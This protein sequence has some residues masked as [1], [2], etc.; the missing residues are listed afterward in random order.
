MPSFTLFILISRLVPE[1]SP[2]EVKK[3]GGEDLK[4]IRTEI[5][6]ITMIK[7]PGKQRG[8]TMLLFV[9]FLAGMIGMIGLATDTGDILVNK[10]RLQ[11]AMDATALSAATILS[12][13]PNRD[14][15][16]ATNNAINTFNLFINTAGN[17]ALSSGVSANNLTF[18]FSTTLNPFTAQNFAPGANPPPN[19]VRVSTNALAVSPILRQVVATV[20]AAPVNVPAVATAGVAGQNCNLTP[21]VICPRP[22]PGGNP[23]VGCG[24]NSGFNGSGPGCN[25]ISFNELVCLKGGTQAARTGTCQSTNVP[26]GNFGMLNFPNLG[27]GANNVRNLLNGT[28]STCA[29]A[30]G[31][32]N[33]NMVGP[34]SQGIDDRFDNDK[35]NDQYIPTGPPPSPSN[36]YI[37]PYNLEYTNSN[38]DNPNGTDWFRAMQVPIV[39]NCTSANP[40][41]I[42]AT[43]FFLTKR[44]PHTGTGNEIYGELLRSC[45]GTGSIL[46]SNVVLFG[47]TKVVLFRSQGSPDS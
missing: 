45:P 16:N 47:P 40:N 39:D 14:T 22:D 10:T 30:S 46:P 18:Q 29:N 27:P 36:Y 1:V 15:A 8:A 35:V 33:G 21:L 4:K 19:F 31:W 34:I 37:N 41:I 28:I 24:P 3:S 17:G 6:R 5:R 11:H 12:N 7:N 26:N 25:G 43:C 13:D 2:G 38:W 42:A 23:I 44:V 9:A 20:N 32:E